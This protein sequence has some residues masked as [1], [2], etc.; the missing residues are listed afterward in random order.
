MPM[1][2]IDHVCE[3]TMTSHKSLTFDEQVATPFDTGHL[4]NAEDK[5]RFMC[6]LQISFGIFK[7]LKALNKAMVR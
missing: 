3:K 1:R 4:P 6:S 7:K 2:G 5:L